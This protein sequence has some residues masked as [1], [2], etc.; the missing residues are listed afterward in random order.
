[1]RRAVPGAC[2]EKSTAN[3]SVRQPSRPHATDSFPSPRNPRPRPRAERRAPAV[4]R[5]RAGETGRLHD[6]GHGRRRQRAGPRLWARKDQRVVAVVPARRPHRAV[7]RHGRGNQRYHMLATPL[8]PAS[9]DTPLAR[10]LGNLSPRRK[11]G[12]G[13]ARRRQDLEPQAGLRRQRRCGRLNWSITEPD[14]SYAISISSWQWSLGP[15]RSGEFSART[16]RGVAKTV[17]GEDEIQIGA[18]R[19][20]VSGDSCDRSER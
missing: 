18:S 16:V 7:Q 6:P 4:G 20:S 14:T 9:R 13:R 8:H 1:M 17:G 11:P 19:S 12:F 2:P 5:P 10:V 3:R 15:Q